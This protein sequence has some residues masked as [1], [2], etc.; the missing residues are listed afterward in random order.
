MY[1]YLSAFNKLTFY[2]CQLIHGLTIPIANLSRSNSKCE[3]L[4][5]RFV[6]DFMFAL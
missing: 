1:L 6:V 5:R 3:E 2:P 4:R